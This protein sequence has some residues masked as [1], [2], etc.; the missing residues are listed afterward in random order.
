MGFLSSTV[1]VLSRCVLLLGLNRL[2]LHARP[3]EFDGNGVIRMPIYK[4]GQYSSE[5]EEEEN[6]DKI[7]SRWVVLLVDSSGY[8]NYRHHI[9]SLKTYAY[10]YHCNFL[11]NFLVYLFGL[12]FIFLTSLKTS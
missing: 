5:S 8:G 12:S 9:F 3:A 2:L 6:A 7:S 10:V 11:E 4:Q 1:I